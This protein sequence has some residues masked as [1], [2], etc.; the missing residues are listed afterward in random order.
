MESEREN[1][2]PRDGFNPSHTHTHNGDDDVFKHARQKFSSGNE[3]KKKKKLN[4]PSPDILATGILKN[5]LGPDE[6]PSGC[7]GVVGTGSGIAGDE[8]ET[9]PQTSKTQN[10]ENNHRHMQTKMNITSTPPCSKTNG[11]PSSDPSVASTVTGIDRE[12]KA[13]I[14]FAKKSAD[15]SNRLISTPKKATRPFHE[16][17]GDNGKNR[18][19]ETSSVPKTNAIR[20]DLADDIHI[21]S[22]NGSIHKGLFSSS[23][24][25]GGN[26]G[27]GSGYDDNR[28]GGTAS[29]VQQNIIL[30]RE[31]NESNK[32][33][34]LQTDN[35][36]HLDR[37]K[38]F[39]N[40]DRNQID[41]ISNSR[42]VPQTN[43]VRNMTD[44]H[45]RKKSNV[46]I[47]QS[48]STN[49][50]CNENNRKRS[51]SR[52]NTSTINRGKLDVNC[53]HMSGPLGT[54]GTFVTNKKINQDNL[55][56]DRSFQDGG[57]QQNK[58]TENG[59][60]MNKKFKSVPNVS[61]N[62]QKTI[63]GESSLPSENTR[64]DN[65]GAKESKIEYICIGD[66]DSDDGISAEKTPEKHKKV[67]SN[68]GK[69]EDPKMKSV[70]HVGAKQTTV[71]RLVFE[72]RKINKAKPLTLAERE[73]MLFQKQDL[74]MRH[75][76]R[77]NVNEPNVK[78]YVTECREN[79]TPIV[80]IGHKGWVNFARPWLTELRRDGQS[81]PASR[82]LLRNIDIDLKCPTYRYEVDVEKMIDHIG[83][84]DVPILRKNYN[85][86]NPIS[87]N[88]KV[89]SFLKKH[90]RSNSD[91]Y[92]SDYYYLHQ[93][94]FPLSETA[95]P[96]LCAQCK[97]LP[98]GIFGEDI[99]KY[100]LGEEMPHCP[101]DNPF[102]YI[103]MGSGGT[104]SKLHADPGGLEIT[105]AV[106][107]GEKECILVHRD[108]GLDCFYDLDAS[109]DDVDLNEYPLMSQ[110]RIWKTTIKPGDI[111][112][113]PQVRRK[114]N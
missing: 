24:R 3:L 39:R 80:L 92:V 78:E 86:R 35:T 49:G 5:L 83:M 46:N 22:K 33:G 63:S 103:F 70:Q 30:R 56:T 90:W 89:S 57:N 2:R 74:K 94:Q 28:V 48:S 41:R 76:K 50:G 88:A 4:R 52:I 100:Y 111:L 21:H 96:K 110:A 29:N 53:H 25:P 61:G 40:N 43:I 19:D 15:T 31:R 23:N 59:A 62:S 58:S 17:F 105:I 65:N 11:R 45:K 34:D 42:N 73:K 10:A 12:L 7:N 13:K 54:R 81:V 82:R 104:K 97:P 9:V 113:M 87:H 75:V 27:S 32:N 109:L 79:G 55:N 8:V 77:V 107:T 64:G 101:W 72:K 37:H 112:L 18:M 66:S 85:E 93:W 14:N 38:E 1:K 91:D 26:E 6:F 16:R 51:P 69:K 108:D 84:E 98:R 60:K 68:F 20:K 44:V 95:G 102:Q 36:Y 47:F 99:L 71:K 67:S 106:I 114:I